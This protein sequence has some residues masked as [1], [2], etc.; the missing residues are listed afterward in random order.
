ME[1]DIEIVT[2]HDLQTFDGATVQLACS[3]T[4]RIRNLAADALLVV[5]RRQ[6]NDQLYRDLMHKIAEEPAVSPK[7]LQ[8]IGD[9]LAPAII[10]AAVYSGHRYALE[11]EDD[12]PA[13]KP[14]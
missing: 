1:L 6:P 2:G 8:R 9:C 5:G 3:Y 14:R 11:L 10:A 4:G 7:S 12:R 13:R